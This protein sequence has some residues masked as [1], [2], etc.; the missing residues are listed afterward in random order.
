MIGLRIDYDD[1]CLWV[2]QDEGLNDWYE[3][4][5]ANMWQ[6]ASLDERIEACQEIN[7]SIFASRHDEPPLRIF[8][9]TMADLDTWVHDHDDELI[10]LL[11]PGVF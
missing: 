6:N 8:D 3:R 1:L 7:E 9:T 2:H 5:V 10:R 4:D 11:N